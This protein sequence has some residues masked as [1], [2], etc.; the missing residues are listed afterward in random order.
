MLNE[1]G[2][3]ILGISQ[4]GKKFRPS[5]WIERI[6]T[7]FASFDTSHRLHY[8]PRVSPVKRDGQ[9]CLFVADSLAEEDPAAYAFIMH[10]AHSNRLQIAKKDQ[11]PD[12][13]NA[14]L[15][16]LTAA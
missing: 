10:F 8:N 16:V 6:A 4:S 5:D 7:D 9:S 14:S 11:L 2:H 3:F 1:E 15:E 12:G 13:A